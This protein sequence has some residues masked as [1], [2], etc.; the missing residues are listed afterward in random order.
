MIKFINNVAVVFFL[1]LSPGIFVV[2]NATQLT[3]STGV[4][5]GTPPAIYNKN[6]IANRVDFIRSSIVIDDEAELDIN[7]T[8]DLSWLIKDAEGDVDNNNHTLTTV[9]WIC[10]DA[11][12]NKHVLTTGVAQYVITP[13]DKGC[14]LGVNF[15]PTTETGAPQESSQISI[16]DI[17][18]YDGSDN[19]P[20]GPVNPHL[21]NVTNYIVAPLNPNAA[22]DVPADVKLRTAFPGAQIQI[23][24]DNVID[25]VDWETSNEAIA[26]VSNTG[27]VTIHAKGP[28]KITARRKEQRTSIIFNPQT[29]F[30]FNTVS[31]L[32][33]NDAKEWCE[34]QGYRLPT[35]DELSTAANHREVPSDSL[36][37]EWGRSL[38][39]VPHKGG[40]IW[41][42]VE[43]V[44]A[45]HAFAY[46]YLSDGHLSSNASTVTEGVACVVP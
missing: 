46:M 1:F 31:T 4:I 22:Y 5:S 39:D 15:T 9:E 32:D 20:S 18:A 30:I 27:L 43:R 14:T 23:E 11:G 17:S 45:T 37:Q 12:N 40:V 42:S 24:T 3:G 26:S 19:I 38:E 29:F 21:I 13:Y 33:W 6:N 28:F 7:D 16:E 34:N 41:S 10:T 2:A 35:D 44:A 25:Q 36:W 8:V